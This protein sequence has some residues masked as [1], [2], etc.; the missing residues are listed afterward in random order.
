MVD[1]F[2]TK[3]TLCRQTSYVECDDDNRSP[4]AVILFAKELVSNYL[5]KT[6]GTIKFMA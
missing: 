5:P 3:F 4:T 2:R 6:V 1:E